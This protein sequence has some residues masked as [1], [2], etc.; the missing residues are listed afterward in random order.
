MLSL[1]AS[2][3]Y[4]TFSLFT[5]EYP[6]RNQGHYDLKLLTNHLLDI[7]EDLVIMISNCSKKSVLK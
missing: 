7:L 1:H 3:L 6:T 5:S 2:N 4:L